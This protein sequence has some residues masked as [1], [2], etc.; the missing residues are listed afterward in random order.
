MRGEDLALFGTQ[1]EAQKEAAPYVARDNDNWYITMRQRVMAIIY[2]VSLPAMQ[3][4]LSLGWIESIIILMHHKNDNDI[5]ITA[6]G[7]KRW[8][9]TRKYTTIM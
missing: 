5:I 7:D 3:S 9:C 2:C 1:K 6:L 8:P 4:L